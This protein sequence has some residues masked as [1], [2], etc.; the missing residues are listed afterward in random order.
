MIEQDLPRIVDAITFAAHAHR[1]QRRKDAEATPYINHPLALLHTLSVEAGIND[2]DVLRAA[3][4]HDY[5]EDCCGGP[6]Q[7][8][9]EEA[10]ALLDQRFGI[11]VR[12]LMD[13][14]S[15]D[16][17]LAKD[18]RKRLQIAHAAQLPHGAKLVKLADKI[19]NLRDIIA[20]PPADWPL[21]RRQA[22]FDWAGQVISALQGTHAGLEKLAT[23]ALAMRPAEPGIDAR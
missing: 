6:G 13:A 14:V 15:D 9:L 12:R 1:L 4:L 18:E 22:Y 21:A 23:A 19:V 10:R 3:I 16:K 5:L 8:T 2:V 17:T 7:L 20:S 11:D